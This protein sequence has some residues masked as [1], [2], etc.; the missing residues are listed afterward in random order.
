M[1][2]RRP[3]LELQPH[4]HPNQPQLHPHVRKTALALAIIMHSIARLVFRL[5]VQPPPTIVNDVFAASSAAAA[6]PAAATSAAAAPA[7]QSAPV[8]EAIGAALEVQGKDLVKKVNGIIQF[9]VTAGKTST[10][11][12]LDLKSGS[13]S[14]TN[15]PA[16]GA[17]D[18]TLTVADEDFFALSTGSL[19]PQ[20]VSFARQ[21]VITQY[22]LTNSQRQS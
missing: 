5:M 16:K 1:L 11:Y 20:Q 3:P 18:L 4:R 10:W 2:P 7:L 14:L 9:Q 19:N 21:S 13:G 12:V 22:S 15:G 6:K 17:T 8:F